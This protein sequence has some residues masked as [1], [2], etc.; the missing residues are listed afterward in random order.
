MGSRVDKSS[1]VI[2]SNYS[3]FLRS[4]KFKLRNI[5]N[6]V[7]QNAQDKYSTKYTISAPQRFL[8][9]HNF[10]LHVSL[11][12]FHN[13]CRRF[14]SVKMSDRVRCKV[15]LGIA[16]IKN[17]RQMFRIIRCDGPETGGCMAPKQR[18]HT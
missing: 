4:L 3:F 10:A 9:P 13:L 16:A 2:I 8:L 18:L 6:L 12:L 5:L 1:H 11:L 17:P 7:I 14:S 15:L